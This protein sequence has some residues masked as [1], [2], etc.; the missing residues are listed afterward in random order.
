M[1]PILLSIH[2]EYVGKIL[3]GEKRY[4]YRRKTP[5]D[6]SHIMIYA[7]APVKKYMAV[8]EVAGT[9]L[10]PPE[11]IWEKTHARGGV[12]KE[13]FMAYFEG[14]QAMAYRLGRIFVLPPNDFSFPVIQSFCYLPGDFVEKIVRDLPAKEF[15]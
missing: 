10:G 7:T 1:K 6:V 11:E 9:L 3:S 14:R 2:P 5:R 13:K 15:A 12:S 4:E 8:A